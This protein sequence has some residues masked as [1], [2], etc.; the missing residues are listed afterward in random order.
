MSLLSRF[1]IWIFLNITAC[2]L[3][4]VALFTQTTVN[5]KDTG[6]FIKLIVSEFWASILWAFA[7]PAQRL[8]Y[9]LMTPIQLSLSSEVFT[10]LS[11][12]WANKFWLN[13]PST[14]D[15]YMGMI[16]ILSGMGISKTRL[17]G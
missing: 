12:L 11:Q 16:L 8:G 9:T 10:F 7:I 14:I 5:V 1:I 13:L 6:I 2:Y 4:I 3:T 17:I 15:D